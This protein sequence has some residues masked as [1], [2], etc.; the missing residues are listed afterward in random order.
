[1]IVDAAQ[2]QPPA[3]SNFAINDVA[4]TNITDTNASLTA[5]FVIDYSIDPSNVDFEWGP[6]ASYMVGESQSLDYGGTPPFEDQRTANVSGLQ[7]GCTYHWMAKLNGSFPT[8]YAMTSDQSFTTTGTSNGPCTIGMDTGTGQ[9]PAHVQKVAPLDPA[10]T[11]PVKFTPP[12]PAPAPPATTTS[13]TPAPPPTTTSTTTT[14]PP[15]ITDR[16]TKLTVVSPTVHAGK[17]L[18]IAVTLA[19]AGKVSVVIVRHVPASGHGKHRHK[20]HDV[21]VGSKTFTG[22]VGHNMLKLLTI[23]GHKLSA[24]RY[25]AK[26]TAG[27]KTHSV[28]FVVH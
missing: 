28:S 14:P 3:G 11:L 10:S 13:T 26:L 9:G 27:G 18:T 24:G 5:T 25:T 6:T 4:T 22:M 19:K 2:S 20:A 7:P 16:I 21:T 15:P 8:V 23:K 1:V 17:P 12:P